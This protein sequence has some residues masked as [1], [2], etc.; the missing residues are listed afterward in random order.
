M[1]ERCARGDGERPG[2]PEGDTHVLAV[3]L[4]DR[5]GML[6]ER[7]AQFH[8]LHRRDIDEDVLCDFRAKSR[9]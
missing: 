7:P 3:G 9:S 4:S 5:L 6:R 1:D 8:V 2:E